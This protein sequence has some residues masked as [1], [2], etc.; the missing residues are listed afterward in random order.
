[1][2]TP[3]FLATLMLA[4]TAGATEAP[5]AP[6]TPARPRLDVAFVL[7]TTGSMGDEI[8]VVKEKLVSI[9]K[10]LS[11]GQP[12][13]DVRFA[14][15]AFRDRGDAYVTRKLDFDRNIERVS[16]WIRGLGADGGGDEPEDVAAALHA[17][18]GLEWDRGAQVARVAFLVGDAGPQRYEGAPTWEKAA[19]ALKERKIALHTIG[20]SGMGAD[21]TRVFKALAE[22]TKGDFEQLTYSRIE[23]LADGRSRTILNSGGATYV[24]EGELS[25]AE[26]K[27]GADALVAAGR[28]RRSEEA[29]YGAGAG[30]ASLGTRGTGSG[31]GGYGAGRAAAPV[32]ASET[33]NNLDEEIAGKLMNAAS[34]AGATYDDKD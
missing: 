32:A 26:W 17:T 16:G 29:G 19:T 28:A 2:R 8:D 27:K 7:D 24:A 14:V 20:C 23:K 4:A 22:R 13:P 31:G 9:A 11:A 1:M 25:E 3:A 18:L 15:V 30:L 34:E 33:R 21:A 10:R 12:R 5:P 6:N